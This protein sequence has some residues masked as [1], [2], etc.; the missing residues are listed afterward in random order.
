MFLSNRDILWAID[1]Q[2]LVIQ[3]RS[4][5]FGLGYDDTSLAL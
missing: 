5:E 2:Q 3:P 4:E 1:C